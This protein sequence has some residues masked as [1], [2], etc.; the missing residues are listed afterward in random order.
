MNGSA[1][2]VVGDV[3]QSGNPVDRE[4]VRVVSGRATSLKLSGGGQVLGD[5][6]AKEVVEMR[7]LLAG[8]DNRVN[9]L[10]HEQIDIGEEVGLRERGGSASKENGPLHVC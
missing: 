5:L 6:A 10:G 4:I 8:K 3:E 1:A 2:A 9:V 7:L